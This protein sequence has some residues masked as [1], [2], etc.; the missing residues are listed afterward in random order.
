MKTILFKFIFATILFFANS[1][2]SQEK[3]VEDVKIF[4]EN[5]GNSIIKIASDSKMS[6]SQKK[7]KIISEVDSVVDATW[8]SKFVL[9]KYYRDLSDQQ[10]NKFSELYRQFMI[11]TYGPKFKNYNGKKFE[12]TKVEK[13][14]IFYTAHTQ[15]F[16]KDSSNQIFIDFR[17]K[18]QNGKLFVIDFIAEGISLLESQRSEFN[19]AINQSG[20]DQFISSLEKRVESLKK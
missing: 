8:I 15:F 4:V 7:Q 1:G 18:E 9:G 14:A 11:N 6:E 13:Q 12:V 2:F 20:I 10:K 19:S 5:I 16:P 17:V 3:K